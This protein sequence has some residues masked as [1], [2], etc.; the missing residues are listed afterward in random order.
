MGKCP[1]CGENLLANARECSRCGTELGEGL[2]IR[3]P[4]I[5]TVTDSKSAV[6]REAGVLGGI[7]Q[8]LSTLSDSAPAAIGTDDAHPF[9]PRR[10]PPAIELCVLNDDSVDSG[11]II[12]IRNERFVIGRGDGDLKIAN[13]DG[14]STRHAE[15]NRTWADGRYCWV[16]RDLG[17]LNGTYVRVQSTP[18]KHGDELLFGHRVF[19]FDTSGGHQAGETS[20][21]AQDALNKTRGLQNFT[22]E[23]LQIN[24]PEL[25]EVRSD[26]QVLR[27]VLPSQDV[28]VGR[29]ANRCQITLL[30]D[31]TV[32][33]THARLHCDATE[34]WHLEDSGSRNGVWLRIR[35]VPLTDQTEFQLGQ[36]RFLVSLP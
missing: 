34:V 8:P 17:S 12:W 4:L 16:L 22:P 2:A 6:R 20:A 28:C 3:W 15:L 5:R 31:P 25:I 30:D 1:Y 7:V 26:G 29:D 18:I 27:F 32:S 23:S 11:E 36:Q 10:R 21:L 14:I 35:E 19:R 13:D 33:L 9:R 24:L